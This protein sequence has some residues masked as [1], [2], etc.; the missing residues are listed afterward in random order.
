MRTLVLIIL[1]TMAGCATAGNAID[2]SKRA[3]GYFQKGLAHFQDKNYELA[4]VEFNRSLQTDSSYKL[5]YYYLGIICDFQGKLDE[6]IKYYKEA[7]SL[8]G[9]FSEAYNALGAVYSKQQKWNDALKNYQK[10]LENK[11]YTTPH[12][13][14]LNM[15]RVYMAQKDYNKA[16]ESFRD[17]KRFVNQ[18]FIIYELGTALFEAGRI[19]E[20][21]NEFQEG[22]GL[23]PQNAN[24][25]YSLALALLK[26]GKKK[27]AAVEFKKTAELAPK[28]DLARKAND[29]LKALR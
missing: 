3:E 24:M 19:K 25:R 9:Q 4:S 10:A 8:D 14:Y 27:S 12:V 22:V 16:V 17:A 18:D 23:S 20:S 2:K 6:A 1:L 13:P 26:D 11:L 7:I 29:Y 28:S 21:I 15:G 5:S